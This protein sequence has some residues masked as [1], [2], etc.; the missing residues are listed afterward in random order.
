MVLPA[1]FL[2]ALNNIQFDGLDLDGHRGPVLDSELDP[3]GVLSRVDTNLNTLKV[4]ALSGSSVR[5]TAGAVS[6]PNGSVQAIATTDLTGL[7]SGTWYVV[8]NSTGTLQITPAILPVCYVLAKLVVGGAT[9]DVT[10]WRATVIPVRPSLTPVFGGL[11]TQ[12]IVVRSSGANETVGGTTFYTGTLASPVLMKGLLQCKNFTINSGAYLT[13]TGGGVLKIEASGSV[14]IHGTVSVNKASTG[15]QGFNGSVLCPDTIYAQPGAG[16]GGASGHNAGAPN[17]YSVYT[18]KVGSGGASGFCKT[19]LKAGAT[20]SDITDS[21]TVTVGNGGAGGGCFWVTAAGS[22]TVSG[23]INADGAAGQAASYTSGEG[24]NQYT[25]ISGSGGGSGGRIILQSATAVNFSVAATLSAK[26]GNGG[27]GFCS[28]AVNT[29]FSCLGGG[30]GGGGLI[31]ANAPVVSG[32]EAAS[33]TFYVSGGSAGS[34]SGNGANQLSGST[35]G[36]CEG[37]GGLSASAGGAG[38]SSYQVGSPTIL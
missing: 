11:N 22:V 13:V 25:L 16:F 24:T 30:G 12:N 32:F 23:S 38:L 37:A 14:E 7:T 26:G 15:G 3:A 2:N 19:R 10:D 18:S 6:L 9:V 35:G 21:I 27:N 1:S 36:S 31:F 34:A 4:T 8:V 17:T 29:T 33:G 28:T 20:F 5:V